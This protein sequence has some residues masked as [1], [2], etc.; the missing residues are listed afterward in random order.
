MCRQSPIHF[1]K[2]YV[3][4]FLRKIP[5]L[6]LYFSKVFQRYYVKMLIHRLT[7]SISLP[8]N[9]DKRPI[10][11]FAYFIKYNKK[12]IVNPVNPN[13]QAFVRQARSYSGGFEQPPFYGSAPQEQVYQAYPGLYNNAYSGYGA[14]APS[15]ALTTPA[16][17]ASTGFNLNQLKGIVDR[18][19]GIDGLMGH[20]TR[21]QKI[22]Q[23][24]QQLS[25]MLKVLLGSFGGA[26]ATTARLGEDGAAPAR[27]NSRRRT[28]KRPVKK[29]VSKRRTR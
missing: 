4:T 25:P 26:K 17:A 10:Q 18:M 8:E 1:T 14:V 19:G 6:Q 3:S 13:Q 9:R 11:T 7:I 12:R 15:T 21:F 16:A 2:A 27:K 23:S 29:A 24:I 20:V 22:I 28:S 5:A